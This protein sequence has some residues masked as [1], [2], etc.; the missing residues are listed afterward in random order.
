MELAEG[1]FQVGGLEK[2][3]HPCCREIGHCGHNI[4]IISLL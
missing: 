4:Y 2:Y 3:S 1:G